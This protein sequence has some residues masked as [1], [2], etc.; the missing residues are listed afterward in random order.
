MSAISE[1][2]DIFRKT[3]PDVCLIQSGS[4][5]TQDIM[6][7]LELCAKHGVNVLTITESIYYPW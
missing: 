6:P 4:P 5:L 3:K 1:A 2:D 7:H